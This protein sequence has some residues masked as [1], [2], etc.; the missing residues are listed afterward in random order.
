MA[1]NNRLTAD[2]AKLN[3][4]PETRAALEAIT[5]PVERFLEASRVA[6]ECWRKGATMAQI[7]DERRFAIVALVH[8][9][10]VDKALIARGIGAVDRRVVDSAFPDKDSQGRRVAAKADLR[11]IPEEWKR[12]EASALEAARRLHQEYVDRDNR[13]ITAREVRR[14]LVVELTD[15]M[16]GRVYKTGELA[17][18]VGHT[19]ALMSQNITGSSNKARGA[20]R[21]LKA[22]RKGEA[23]A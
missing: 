11:K 21:A 5:D 8:H 6:D 3:S 12:S 17:A 22:S 23:A 15:G 16:Y 10:H 14:A 7:R 19:T 9:H 4:H 2:E 20:R 13:A 1:T 18:M